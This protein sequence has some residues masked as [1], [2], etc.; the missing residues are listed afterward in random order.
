M[1]FPTQRNR[2]TFR[3]N[4]EL[5]RASMELPFGI[6]KKSRAPSTVSTRPGLRTPVHARRRAVIVVTTGL[7]VARS[8]HEIGTAFADH[9]HGRVDVAADEMRHYG[10]VDNA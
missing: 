4:R 9:D 7:F 5:I 1:N 6:P 10:S 3:R 8:A 2:E